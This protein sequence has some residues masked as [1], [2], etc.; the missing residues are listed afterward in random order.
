[1]IK[2]STDKKKNLVV[3]PSLSLRGGVAHHVRTLLNSP[4]KENF[5]LFHFRVGSEYQ[6]NRLKIMIRSISTPFRFLIKLWQVKPNIV[7]FNPSFDR[8]SLLRELTMLSICKLLRFT[9][10]V[11]FHGCSLSSLM[12]NNRLPYYL[13]FILK[14]ATHFIVLTETQKQP[15]LTFVPENKITVI[16]NMVD[17]SL[18]IKQSKRSNH[19]ILFMSRIDIVKGVYDIIQAIPEVISQLPETRF[20]FAGEGPDKVKLQLLSCTNG[21]AKQVKFLGYLDDEQKVNFLAQGDLFLFPS[22]HYEGIPY[23]L[24]EAMAAGL[25][26]IATPVGG[27]PEIIKDG[28]HCKMVPPEQPEKLAES[29]IKLLKNKRLRASMAKNNRATVEIKY[30]C[31]IVCQ[32][33][34]QLYEKSSS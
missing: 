22:H 17:T 26:V 3:G 2:N 9:S 30:D 12:K 1:M 13:Q 33:F 31:K 24:L 8:K 21:L 28:E 18:F 7:H 27:V 16:P 6:D 32:Q 15:L 20:L 14:W 34:Q 10:L 4:L 5:E 25:P 11:Q 19:I 23:A 29:I